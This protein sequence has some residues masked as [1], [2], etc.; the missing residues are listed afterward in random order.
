MTTVIGND[1]GGGGGGGGGGGWGGGG[2]VEHFGG[3]MVVDR[4]S[5]S[6]RVPLAG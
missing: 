1:W 2:G 5:P 6:R 4:T 3:V